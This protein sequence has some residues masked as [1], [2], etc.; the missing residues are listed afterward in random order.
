V[1]V[2]EDVASAIEACATTMRFATGTRF[3]VD[4]GRSL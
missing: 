4:G 3:V 1:G 2:V